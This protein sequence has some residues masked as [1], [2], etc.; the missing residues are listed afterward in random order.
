MKRFTP[1]D[2]RSL[3][4]L[5]LLEVERDGAYAN[6]ALSQHLRSSTLSESDRG[7]AT[8]LVNGTLRKQLFYD[9][10]I[11]HVAER[12]PARIDVLARVN[13]RMSVHQLLA[14]HSKPH[15]VVNEAVA[16]QKRL[17]EHRSAGFVNAVLRR[18]ASLSAES[19]DLADKLGLDASVRASHP[20]WVV[21][22]LRAALSAEHREDEIDALL[23]A[24]NT[25]N[26]VHLASLPTGDTPRL[27]EQDLASV[28]HPQLQPT[29][30]SPIGWELRS[31]DPGAVSR[32]ASD[33]TIEVRVQDQGSQ[34]AA[35]ALSEAPVL[36]PSTTDASTPSENWWLD[37]C[38]GPGGKSA[39]L[40]SA[41]AQQG[42]RLHSNE[43]AE[44]RADLVRLA[45]QRHNDTVTVTVGD[46]T[47][48]ATLRDGGYQRILVDAPCSGL[49]ALRRRPDARNRKREDDLAALVTLQDQL[50]DSALN[51][52]QPGG[53][54]AYVTCSPVLAETREVID[55]AL[56]A[57]GE[58]EEL[59]AKS[60][61]RQIA[62]E[63]IDLAGDELSAQ[64]WPHRH[65]TDAMFIALLRRRL[66]E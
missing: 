53:V 39:V 18:V 52:V 58:I 55:R 57:H 24:N 5:V 59:D 64:L 56:A 48:P 23:Q 61:L 38:A 50:L 28:T 66:E 34:L 43:M 37:L 51:A 47:E 10:V 41:A 13:L 35:L 62:R 11:E 45:V 6:L 26:R 17:G 49:G 15:A 1:R 27:L 31:G 3:A 21:R 12:P 33:D 8:E 46:G 29:G 44:H 19:A 4:V 25:A 9:A 60:L 32:A 40:A 16:V 20:D 42:A 14:L 63:P 36:T 2:A 65:N 54:V 7:F 22:Q 30:L